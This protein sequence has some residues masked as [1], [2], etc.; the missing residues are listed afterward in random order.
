MSQIETIHVYIKSKT[1]YI[2]QTKMSYIKPYY[3]LI[4]YWPEKSMIISISEKISD[5]L[6]IK[7]LKAHLISRHLALLELIIQELT[8]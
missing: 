8:G 7:L 5:F 2:R 1:I 4:E 3:C 6:K